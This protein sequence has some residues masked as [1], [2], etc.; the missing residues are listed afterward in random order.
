MT[1]SVNGRAPLSQHAHAVDAANWQESNKYSFKEDPQLDDWV[2]WLLAT[3][4]IVE[5][6]R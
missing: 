1:S 2:I 5:E 4:G 3:G 6:G